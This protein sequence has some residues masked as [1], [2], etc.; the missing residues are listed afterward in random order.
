MAIFLQ[1]QVACSKQFPNEVKEAFITDLFSKD[2]D[3]RC[4]INTSKTVGNIS[5]HKPVG[6]GPFVAYLPKSGVATA[7][8]SKTVAGLA[9]VGTVW[10]LIDAF[11]DEAD[12]LLH[13]F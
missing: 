10:T 11:E 5:F 12:N 9:E 8:R 1:V 7:A 3:E 4:M 2:G 13:D 6:C